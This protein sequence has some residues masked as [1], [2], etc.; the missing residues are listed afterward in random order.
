MADIYNDKPNWFSDVGAFF[1]RLRGEDRLKVSN[2]LTV[3]D[4]PIT[5][6]EVQNRMKIQS[7]VQHVRN[8]NFSRR[9]IEYFDEYRRMVTTFPIVKAAI[10]IYSEEITTQDTDGNVFTIECDNEKVKKLLE[11]CYFDNLNLNK[12]A[13]K[14]ARQMCMFGNTFCFLQTRPKDGVVDLV[15]LPPDNMVREQMYNPDDLE[16]Y[17]FLWYGGGSNSQYE[18]WE[19]VHFRNSEDIEMEPYGVSIL[20][21]IIDTWRRVVLIREAL[22]IYRITR[23]PSRLLFKIGTDGMTG[24]EAFRFAQEMKKEVT[25]K[26]LVNPQ[27]G[28]IDFKYNPLSIEEN[29]FMPTYEGSPSDVVPIEGASNLDQVE[30]YKIIKDDLFAGLKIPKS[31]LSFEEDLSNKA[32]LSEEDVRFAKTI[33]KLQADFVE[34]IVHIGIVHLHHHG[35]SKAEMQS[36]KI[37]M[38]NPSTTSEK[39]KLELEEQRISIAKNAWDPTNPGLNLMSLVDV[40]RKYLKF[41]DDE[42]KNTIKG[43]FGEKKLGWRLSKLSTDGTYDE[44]DMEKRLAQ[45]KQMGGVDANDETEKGFENLIFESGSLR[46]TIAKKINEEL[47][48]MFPPIIGR[49]TE[50]QIRT[51]KPTKGVLAESLEQ[52]KKDFEI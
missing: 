21:C 23:A 28:E 38:N 2:K 52:A 44:P 36:F 18:P 1:D 12:N 50:N 3:L 30:D 48:G 27:T 42:I 19:I 47:D 29:L 31:F 49:A 11:Q 40:L 26:P 35:C 17:R 15:F 41:T 8:K 9:H 45:L 33:N 7:I 20:R 16:A 32:A 25:K 4:T 5:S 37:K 39:K 43:Q 51:T 22:V 24:E 6:K 34:G 13:S 14:I 10:D 46:S